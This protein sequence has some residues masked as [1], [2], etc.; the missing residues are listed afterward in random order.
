MTL[1][2]GSFRPGHML[3]L[4]RTITPSASASPTQADEYLLDVL[5]DGQTLLSLVTAPPGF[6]L[7]VAPFRPNVLVSAARDR[8]FQ[9]TFG[10]G[11]PPGT[12]QAVGRLV[13]PGGNPCW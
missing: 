12:Y 10:G 4:D 6:A 7:G 1:N 9:F 2:A 8:V 11:E 3:T 5:P 13:K